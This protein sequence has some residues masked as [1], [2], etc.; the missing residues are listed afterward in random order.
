MSFY[1]SQPTP[2]SGRFWGCLELA[3]PWGCSSRHVCTRAGGREGQEATCRPSGRPQ[4]TAPAGPM[5]S[6]PL[7]RTEEMLPKPQRKPHT[8]RPGLLA[9]RET[10]GDW[11]EFC[12]AQPSPAPQQRHVPS[13]SVHAAPFGHL[14]PASPTVISEASGH[15]HL[16]GLPAGP[17]CSPRGLRFPVS[18]GTLAAR[19]L[20]RVGTLPTSFRAPA[21]SSEP[22]T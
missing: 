21:P 2:T 18:Q 20:A 12:G 5:A 6:E 7:S 11:E 15:H 16:K 9:S 14:R 10:A 1:K 22:G 17:V 3:W 4:P 8:P 19:A 13:C